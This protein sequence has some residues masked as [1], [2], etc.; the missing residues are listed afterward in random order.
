MRRLIFAA[1]VLGGAPAAARAQRI[2]A[3]DLL[4]LPLGTLA[5]PL[6]LAR[7]LG[8]G[9]WNPATVAITAPIRVRVGFAALTTGAA[10]GVGSQVLSAA[11]ALPAATTVGLSVFRASVRDLQ[12]TETDPQTLGD[13]GYGTTVASVTAARE[14]RW[15]TAGVALRYRSGELDGRRAGAP[16]IDAGAL[17]RV[18]WGPDIRVAVSSF[19]WRPNDDVADRQALVAATDL[20]LA[21]IT[22]TRELRGGYSLVAT[23]ALGRDD[24]VHLDGRIA[25]LTLAGGVLRATTYDVVTWGSRLGVGLQHARYVVALSREERSTGLPAVYQITLT[26]SF[27]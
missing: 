19:M 18:P 11:V 23:R 21:G 8:D 13:V 17:G 4:D 20:R 7:T 26:S 5:E 15:V 1:L 27:Q 16:G 25:R 14:W 10:Q 12:R 6:A 3:R 9:L 2:P 24:Y 22:G